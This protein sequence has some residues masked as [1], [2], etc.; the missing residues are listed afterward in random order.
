MLPK[1]AGIAQN[2]SICGVRR[3]TRSSVPEAIRG[4]RLVRRARQGGGL[5]R[6]YGAFADPTNKEDRDCPGWVGVPLPCP[7][8]LRPRSRAREE[9]RYLFKLRDYSSLHGDIIPLQITGDIIA[10]QSQEATRYL[11]RFWALC[12]NAAIRFDPG[13]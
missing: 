10:L 9:N 7:H 5:S 13:K 4:K 12:Y 8:P 11:A 3:E 6:E 1:H 2:Q